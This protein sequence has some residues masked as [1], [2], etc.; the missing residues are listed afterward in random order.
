MYEIAGRWNSQLVARASGTGMGDLL[1]DIS[2]GGSGATSPSIEPEYLLLW[3]NTPKP[4]SPFNLTPFAIT[5]N[6]CP[7]DTLR[8]YLCPT[9]CRLRPDQRAFEMGKYERAN[10]LKQKQE[11]KQ[12]T[13]RKKRE[14]GIIPPHRARWFKPLSDEDSGEKTWKPFFEGDAVSYWAERERV[15][16]TSEELREWAGVDHIFIDDEP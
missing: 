2:V 15:R 9:D 5:L 4:P 8:P 12:R 10:E 13:T 7:D 11:E 16:K 1:P 14:Q 3:R 6:D